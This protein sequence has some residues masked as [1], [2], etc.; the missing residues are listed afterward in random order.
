[1]P[2]SKTYKLK[3]HKGAAKRF[4][5][6][7]DG[8]IKCRSARRNHGLVKRAPKLKRHMRGGLDL[9]GADAKNI[10]NMLFN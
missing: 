4:R 1:M 2:K 5:R 7:A 8:R 3:T 9:Q 10:G 6:G